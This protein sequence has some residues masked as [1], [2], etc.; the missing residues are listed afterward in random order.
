MHQWQTKLQY[1]FCKGK[2]YQLCSSQPKNT[3]FTICWPKCCSFPAH[4][5]FDHSEHHFVVHIVS[6]PPKSNL[7]CGPARML[8]SASCFCLVTGIP[9]RLLGFWQ[10]EHLRRF[11]AVEG[12]FCF[13]GGSKCGK[14]TF[15]LFYSLSSGW[16]IQGYLGAGLCVFPAAQL[17]AIQLVIP[18]DQLMIDG[19]IHE[20]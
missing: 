7:S 5:S 2:Q 14:G 9:P 8:L 12:K 6:L 10:M 16:Y 19:A 13:E 18:R 4:P 15:I 11:G 20:G 3:T 17:C 1:Q